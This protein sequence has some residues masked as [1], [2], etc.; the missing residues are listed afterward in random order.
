MI[1]K[2]LQNLGLENI[3]YSHNTI[4]KPVPQAKT[5][6]A[7]GIPGGGAGRDMVSAIT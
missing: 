4:V 2:V 1:F 7:T 3:S 5:S 6:V